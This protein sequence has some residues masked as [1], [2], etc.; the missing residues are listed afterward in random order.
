MTA[1][2]CPICGAPLDEYPAYGE[3]LSFRCNGDL[4]DHWYK[5]TGSSWA[6]YRWTDESGLYHTIVRD[7][8]PDFLINNQLTVPNFEFD[9]RD[10]AN[11]IAKIKTLMAFQ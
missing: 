6:Y 4:Y 9:P 1:D 2:L 8:S 10:K 11:T 7:D 3:T 5:A